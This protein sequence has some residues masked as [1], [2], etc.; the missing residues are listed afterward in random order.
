MPSG[1]ESLR[2]GA[3]GTG[4]DPGGE[5]PVPGAAGVDS[6]SPESTAYRV[7]LPA[8]EGPLEGRRLA[9]L[10]SLFTTWGRWKALHPETTVHVD[11]EEAARGFER[12]FFIA[13][14]AAEFER[15]CEAGLRGPLSGAGSEETLARLRAA[16][17][18]Y[19]GDYLP[20][21]LYE[22]WA[23]ETRERLL[24]LY[25]R[26]ADRLAGALIDRDRYEEALNACQAILARDPC[27][28]RA[29]RLAMRAYT[30][31]GNR[32]QALRAYQRCVDVLREQLDVEPSPETTALGRNLVDK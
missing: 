8:F 32:P 12:A 23:A 2:P 16:L 4:Q 1:S 11:P 6:N 27:W 13:R 19:E 24:T 21:A 10:P 31:Q 15:Q 7:R 14:D 30:A 9:R 18:L 26:A 3:P 28:E 25:L 5:V 17:D 22:D 20:E 29:Y